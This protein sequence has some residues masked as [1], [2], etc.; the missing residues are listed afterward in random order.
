MKLKISGVLYLIITYQHTEKYK[1]P[2]VNAV[3]TP[4]VGMAPL[5]AARHLLEHSEN[6]NTYT[7]Q[8]AW[9]CGPS[10]PGANLLPGNPGQG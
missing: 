3:K 2:N 6:T 10:P 5:Y 8:A 9:A 4:G 1:K 7:H